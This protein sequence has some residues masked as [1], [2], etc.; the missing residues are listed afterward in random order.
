MP[1]AA[2]TQSSSA[3]GTASAVRDLAGCTVPGLSSLVHEPVP[4]CCSWRLRVAAAFL[5]EALRAAAGRSAAA[6]PPR[7]PPS[8]TMH[9]F[10]LAASAGAA[11]S[12]PPPLSLLTVA[13][14]LRS[15]SSSE[16]L[17]SLVAFSMCSALRFCLSVVARLVA[18]RH[19]LPPIR[20]PARPA[21]LS[22]ALPQAIA[23]RQAWFRR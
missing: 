15:A 23:C 14:A 9:G 1:P 3:G 5:A 16:A 10:R 13:Q 2:T 21:H 19:R 17:A 18:L 11:S 22:G 6:F 20:L 4:E 7:R 12:L 8:G